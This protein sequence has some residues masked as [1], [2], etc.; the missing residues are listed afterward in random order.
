MLY[1]F[2]LSILYSMLYI[3][4]NYVTTR[5]ACPGRNESKYQG[6]NGFDKISFKGHCCGFT[7]ARH[8]GI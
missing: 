1:S 7:Q 6:E 5:R 3:F 4:C 8:L 2:I